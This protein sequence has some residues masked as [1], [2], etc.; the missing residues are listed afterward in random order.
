MSSRVFGR[1]CLPDPSD[2]RDYTY[3][4][5]VIYEM[6][7]KIL[8]EDIGQIQDIRVSSKQTGLREWCSPIENQNGFNS[9]TAHAG[10]G[11]VEFFVT[12]VYETDFRASPFFLYKVTRK[13]LGYE[14]DSGLFYVLQ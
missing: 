2:R 3:N 6:Y 13:L 8:K 5:P 1:G 7:K 4:T 10:V 12:K 9:C 11:L 14:D